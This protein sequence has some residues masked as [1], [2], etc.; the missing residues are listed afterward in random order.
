V[1]DA[2]RRMTAQYAAAEL[3]TND[4][5]VQAIPDDGQLIN[6]QTK[7]DRWEAAADRTLDNY[8]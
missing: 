3:V 2:V 1:P 5:F 4:E 7:A 6:V 8:R